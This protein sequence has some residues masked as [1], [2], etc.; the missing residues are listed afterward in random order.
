MKMDREIYNVMVEA[1]EALDCR[2]R[3]YSGR[4][5]MGRA[6]FGVTFGYGS[7]ASLVLGMLGEIRESADRECVLDA[8]LQAGEASED[9]MGLSSIVYWPRLEWQE[10]ENDETDDFDETWLDAW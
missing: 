4:G 1:F 2:P 10:P 3:S 7:A 8:L 5:M 6:C 9:S